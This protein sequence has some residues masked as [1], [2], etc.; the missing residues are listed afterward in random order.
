MERRREPRFPADA[1]VTVTLLGA[2]TQPPMPGRVEDMSGSGL[3][4]RLPAPIACGAPVKVEGDDM[5]LLGE[6]CR[7]QPA[8]SRTAS[9][10]PSAPIG[11]EDAAGS[12]DDTEYEVGLTISQV[13][14]PV[15]SLERFHRALLGN[16]R[17]PQ[18]G[19]KL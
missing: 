8:P 7:S 4:L 12:M 14:A 11:Q 10:S 16:R 15:S 6:V 3:R 2:V 17:V 9:A 19:I 1:R 5:L 13:L 18:S